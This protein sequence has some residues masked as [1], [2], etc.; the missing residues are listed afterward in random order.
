M[1]K[2]D[3]PI[4]QAYNVNLLKQR[5]MP[6]EVISVIMK[7]R[8]ADA[9]RLGLKAYSG[10]GRKGGRG[11]QIFDARLAAFDELLAQLEAERK[12]MTPADMSRQVTGNPNFRNWWSS[13]MSWARRKPEVYA[14]AFERQ[15]RLDRLKQYEGENNG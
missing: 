14:W 4:L 2:A 5:G 6:P 8:P 13:I 10:A 15:E 12:Y 9:Q 3:C 7:L 1:G 11:K